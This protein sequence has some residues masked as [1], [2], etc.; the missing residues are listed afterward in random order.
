M[1]R[2]WPAWIP[3]RWALPLLAAVVVSGIGM[4]SFREIDRSAVKNVFAGDGVHCNGKGPGG[5]GGSCG[6]ECAEAAE[7]H[8]RGGRVRT[9]DIG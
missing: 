3:R 2:T 5:A 1:R 9:S 4:V 6:R 7:F 8:V